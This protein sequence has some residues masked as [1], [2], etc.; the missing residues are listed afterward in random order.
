MLGEAIV[1]CTIAT[2]IKKWKLKTNKN[3]N[4]LYFLYLFIPHEKL[5]Q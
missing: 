5:R 3:M 4:I 2:A 1:I